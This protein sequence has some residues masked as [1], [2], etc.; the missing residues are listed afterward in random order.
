MEENV[1]DITYYICILKI[2]I[3]PSVPCVKIYIV[4][5]KDHAFQICMV[6]DMM[7]HADHPSIW[8]AEVWC[9]LGW[10][11]AWVIVSSRPA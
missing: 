11:L 10:R 6:L 8:E 3:I 5:C 2:Y 9:P 7:A 1:C 4:Y